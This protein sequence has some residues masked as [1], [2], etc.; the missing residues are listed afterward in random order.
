MTTELIVYLD[1]IFHQTNATSS[2][3]WKVM[4]GV[5]NIK[6]L[7]KVVE[8]DGEH[9]FEAWDGDECNEFRG[10]DGTIFSPFNQPEDVFWS[11]EPAICR[12]MK[13]DPTGKKTKY[14]GVPTRLYTLNY[15]D[16]AN[17]P[18]L[19]CYCRD[20]G[21]C[22]RKGTI[23]LFP[24]MGAPLIASNPHFLFADPELLDK[25]IGLHPNEKDHAVYAHFELVSNKI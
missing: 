24:C 21:E 13:V 3:R 19:Q 15:D 23:D 25:I 5:K 18:E 20:E 16:I 8:I 4:R 6:D 14:R 2:G 7:G 22:P 12:A 1:N 11:T 17:T 9:E 10:T